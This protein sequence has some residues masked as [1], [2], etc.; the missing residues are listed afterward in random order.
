MLLDQNGDGKVCNSDL[1]HH[2]K[3]GINNQ[4]VQRDLNSIMSFVR[5]R[6]TLYENLNREESIP[7]K[8]VL[9]NQH[10][11]LSEYRILQ[12]KAADYELCPDSKKDTIYR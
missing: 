7:E 5:E 10:L 4:M 1:F 11:T 8:I 12:K 9:A 6:Y 2:F 3:N